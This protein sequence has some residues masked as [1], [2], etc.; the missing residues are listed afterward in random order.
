MG[1]SSLF[2][3]AGLSAVNPLG[4]A[5]A[6]GTAAGLA[7]GSAATFLAAAGAAAATAAPAAAYRARA[8]RAGTRRPRNNRR[9]IRCPSL[10]W[11]CFLCRRLL[12]FC[13]RCQLLP[14][15]FLLWRAKVARRLLERLELL[16]LLEP[17]EL[18]LLLLLRLLCTMRRTCTVDSTHAHRRSPADHVR[19]AP[20]WCHGSVPMSSCD[21]RRCHGQSSW[22]GL[23]IVHSRII[24]LPRALLPKVCSCHAISV[25]HRLLPRLLPQSRCTTVI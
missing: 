5:L 9:R 21:L 23:E 17:L 14:L 13:L 10:H 24:V 6:A 15:A 11:L 18:L 1:S 16:E 25:A 22:G 3:L 4:R 12:R 19:L 2:L 7:A 8:G 20:T